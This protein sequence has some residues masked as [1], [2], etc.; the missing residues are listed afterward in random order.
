M[1]IIEPSHIGHTP[2]QQLLGH[3]EDIMKTWSALSDILENTNALSAELKE[4]IRRMLAQKN[5]CQ[6]C[7]AKGKPTGSLTDE[8]SAICIGFTEVYIKLGDQIPTTYTEVLKSHL[9]DKEI[10][11]LITFITFTNAQQQFG[12]M[13]KLQP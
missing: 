10:I 5:G 9:S 4:D 12:A 11:E 7:K 1:T 2:F 8:K 13:M 6:Y 3:H